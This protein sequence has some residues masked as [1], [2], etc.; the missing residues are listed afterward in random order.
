MAG[1]LGSS[2]K[3]FHGGIEGFIRTNKKAAAG[4]D[5]QVRGLAVFGAGKVGPKAKAFVR[6]D[7][8][9]PS[10]KA[11]DDREYLVIAGIDL[12]PQKDIHFMPNLIATIYQAKGVDTVVILRFTVFAKF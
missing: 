10:N 12:M 1:M 5:E 4:S 6:L 9:D 11:T 3:L 7:F 8:F 2:G